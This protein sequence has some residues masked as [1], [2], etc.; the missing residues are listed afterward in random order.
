[1]EKEQYLQKVELANEWMRAYY[2]SDSPLA[3]DEEYDRLIRE[4]KEFEEQNPSLIAK[5]S[6]TQ[7]V[8]PALQS[9]FKKSHHL[10][11]MWSMEDIFNFDELESWAKR[12]R[13]ESGFFIEPKFDGASLNLLY[14][15]GNLIKAA[16]RGDGAVG[17]DVTLNALEI[18][19]IP[20]I[21]SY[22]ERIEIRG[23]VVIFKEDFEKLNEERIQSEQPPFANPRN[24]ASGSL[25]QLDVR[26][27]GQRKLRFYPWGVGENSLSFTKHSQIMA[28]VREL[29]FLKDDFLRLCADL[30]EVQEAYDELLNLRD[31]KPMMM[32]G[33]VVRID[34]LAL[35]KTLGYTVKFPRF[36]AAFKF[37]ALEKTTRLLGVNLQVGRSGAITPVAVLEPVNLDGVVVKSASLH[38]FDEI[39]RLGVKINDFVSIIRSGDVIPKITSVFKTRRTGLECEIA[40]PIFCP[41]CGSELLDEG[42]LIK[43]QNL[44]CKARLVEA[45][46]YFVSKKCLNIDGL[47]SSIVE[48]LYERG[49]INSIEDIFHLK[50]GDFEG[51]EGFKEKKI[52]KLLKAIEVAK[53][54]DLYRFITALGIEHIGEVAAKKLALS[55]G[56]DWHKQDF[57]SY[58]NLDGFGEQMALSLSE[59]VRVNGE[60]IENFYNLLRLML[61]QKQ[62]QNS[63][64][65]GKSFVLTGTLSRPREEVKALIESL[66]GKVN[67]SVS[68]K[69]DFVLFGEAAGSKLEKAKNL[70][71]V[72][73]SE[74][75]FTQLL[76]DNDAL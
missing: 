5:N 14:E 23:E 37:P 4:L 30:K 34:D 57:E 73:L 27:T 17:E 61:P 13:C 65:L 24:A 8:A 25:R 21:I 12:A 62:P 28:F 18:D 52:I 33:M 22:K 66:G 16:T 32:D 51:L 41:E 47:G 72:C 43:C 10:S 29:G 50:F 63:T 45:I 2:E 69:T 44:D 7:K 54:C 9:A 76:K 20:K 6:P 59:F 53:D 39:V 42:A 15:N 11:P 3:S 64:F 46:I 55:F 1:M 19:N 71:I 56:L 49:K 68:A 36:M 31:K 58:K 48:L 70:G 75:D 60:R 26:I 38:N 67:S 74:A 40:R 35:C